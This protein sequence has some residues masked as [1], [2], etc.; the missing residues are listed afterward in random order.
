M[1]SKVYLISGANRCRLSREVNVRL[2]LIKR[3]IGYGL[4]AEYVSPD[5]TTVIA[6]V[7]DTT[8]DTSKSLMTLPAGKTAKYSPLKLTVSRKTMLRT[9][10]RTFCTTLLTT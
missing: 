5:D 10:S 7:R 6:A 2:R 3:G 4:T 8:K 9:P 1:V